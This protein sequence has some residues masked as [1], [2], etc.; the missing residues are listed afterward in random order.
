[1]HANCIKDKHYRK[2]KRSDLSNK[3]EKFYFK[4]KCTICDRPQKDLRLLAS[5]DTAGTSQVKIAYKNEAIQL[6][7]GLE[8]C[9]LIMRE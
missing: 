2:S 5:K 4:E 9:S 1:M 3:P 7:P 8:G 6:N